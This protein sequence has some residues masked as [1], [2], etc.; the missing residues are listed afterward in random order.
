[1]VISSRVAY[2]LAAIAALC[3]AGGVVATAFVIIDRPDEAPADAPAYA[4]DDGPGWTVVVPDTTAG[5]RLLDLAFVRAGNESRLAALAAAGLA[6]PATGQY[7][8]EGKAP[9]PWLTFAG[10]ELAPPLD[11]AGVGGAAEP[12]LG[13]VFGIFGFT[14]D[15]TVRPFDAGPMG[16][17]V[18]CTTLAVPGRQAAACGWVDRWTLGAIVDIR[19]GRTEAQVAELL[20]SMRPD[21][22]VA[23]L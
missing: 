19:P 14:F 20:R 13:S 15:G 8:E 9:E 3:C 23:R 10:G 21:L 17:E 11:E 16:G 22:E 2:W 4:P 6:N 1:M 18:R 5:F 12:R 7:H